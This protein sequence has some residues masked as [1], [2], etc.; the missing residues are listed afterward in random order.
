VGRNCFS[1]PQFYEEKIQYKAVSLL[2]PDEYQ[3]F[4]EEL[5]EFEI[6]WESLVGKEVRFYGK[7]DSVKPQFLQFVSPQARSLQHHGYTL[8]A[9]SGFIDRYEIDDTIYFSVSKKTY[10]NL[11]F[12]RGDLFECTATFQL[13]AGRIVLSQ[14]RHFD[15]EERGEGKVYSEGDTKVIQATGTFFNKQ[16]EKCLQC[17]Q[18]S[19]IDTVAQTNSHEKTYRQ[20][21]CFEGFSQPELC[22]YQP[23]ETMACEHC[24]SDEFNQ[25]LSQK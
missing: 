4:S 14:L 5:I 3:K 21:M 13:D 8:I 19:L 6:W 9:R 1:C 12:R 24:E 7:L 22:T 18:G 10:A 25:V 17:P 20:L 23:M 16:P 2:S 15:F 11:A